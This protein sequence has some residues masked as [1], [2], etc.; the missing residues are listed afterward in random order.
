MN[1]AQGP[2]KAT[3]LQL[4]VTQEEKKKIR[5]AARKADVSMSEWIRKAM[6]K[7]IAEAG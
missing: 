5:A 2:V 3:R 1:K 7:A 6:K 4:V